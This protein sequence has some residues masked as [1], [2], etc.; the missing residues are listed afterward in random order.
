MAL[1]RAMRLASLSRA[2]EAAGRALRLTRRFGSPVIL[3]VEPR[4]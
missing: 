3:R 1:H 2:L 4:G